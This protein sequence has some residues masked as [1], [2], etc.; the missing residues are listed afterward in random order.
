MKKFLLLALVALTLNACK[1][2]KDVHATQRK[3]LPEKF[4]TLFLGM[5]KADAIAARPEMK[6]AHDSE[7]REEYIED[8]EDSE[9]TN[10]VYYFDD[11][12][13]HVLYEIIFIYKSEASRDNVAKVL[14]GEPNSE[15][16]QEWYFDSKEDF[17][18]HCWTYKTKLIVTAELK[19]TEWEEPEN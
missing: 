9:L 2:S 16:S 4:Q 5:S 3:H 8:F 15:N 18:M 14:L 7:F 13:P 11:D 19:G 12:A 6:F 17:R 10:A 1:T